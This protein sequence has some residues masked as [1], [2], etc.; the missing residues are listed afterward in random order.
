MVDGWEGG[1]R[2]APA[3]LSPGMTWYLLRLGGP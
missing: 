2:H 1:K 3:T